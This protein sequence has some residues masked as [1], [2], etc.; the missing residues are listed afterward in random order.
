MEGA[1]AHK[2]PSDTRETLK[3]KQLESEHVGL[4]IL[5]E[6][7]VLLHRGSV[8]LLASEQRTNHHCN[9][10]QVIPARGNQRLVLI[11]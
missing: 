1:Q 4:P 3:G 9:V 2:G 11:G 8:G 7:L 5:H 10:C 6:T